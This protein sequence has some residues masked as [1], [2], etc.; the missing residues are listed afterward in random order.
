MQ[1][2]KEEKKNSVNIVDVL[3]EN[4]SLSDKSLT[5]DQKFEIMEKR[6]KAKEN[7]RKALREKLTKYRPKNQYQKNK[8]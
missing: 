1:K 4:E 5:S 8:T 7:M 6:L 3:D 2:E